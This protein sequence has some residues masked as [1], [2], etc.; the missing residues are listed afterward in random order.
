[1]NTKPM[2]GTPSRHLPL[3]A[4]SASKRVLRASI[5][6]AANELIASTIR[7]RPSRSQRSAIGCSGFST[8]APVSQWIST[9]CVMLG[10][11][12]SAASVAA[13]DTGCASSKGSS[14]QRRPIRLV[15]RAARLQ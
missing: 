3:A 14:V 11:A 7:P 1:M 12:R 4:T 15:S 13:T 5:S 9:T 2:P 8:P 10:S 6:S